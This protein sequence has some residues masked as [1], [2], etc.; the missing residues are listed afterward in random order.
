ME[1]Y[2]F[3]KIFY[4]GLELVG[5]ER[6]PPFECYFTDCDLPNNIWWL[7]SGFS[8]ALILPTFSVISRFGFSITTDPLFC[9][10]KN[11]VIPP[12][13]PKKS[14]APLPA[15]KNDE[16]VGASEIIFWHLNMA[17]LK[18]EDSWYAGYTEG[19][20]CTISLAIAFFTP[21][22]H[23]LKDGKIALFGVRTASLI[24][25]CWFVGLI[26]RC[27]GGWR[28]HKK[29][30]LRHCIID[31]NYPIEYLFLLNI[32]KTLHKWTSLPLFMVTIRFQK[33]HNV[34]TTIFWCKKTPILPWHALQRGRKSH[35][36][37]QARTTTIRMKWTGLSTQRIWRCLSA[38]TKNPA[39]IKPVF[40]IWVKYSQM[41]VGDISARQLTEG[42][43]LI[44]NW[45][46]L[47]LVVTVLPLVQVSN[48]IQSQ[49]FESFNLSL[50]HTI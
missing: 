28:V 29:N 20:S 31:K 17:L 38:L 23:W 3:F 12:P 35:L 4:P 25:P 42:D 33:I 19:D 27:R 13:L 49:I 46:L 2:Y 1:N 8:S 50:F 11:Q 26:L 43:A 40:W 44:R 22:R 34:F 39:R 36:C 18:R 41:T 10:P 30:N 6:N 47:S 7:S 37:G 16:R 5:D 32:C 9:S 15:I 48:E 14:S 21:N 24:H 45:I